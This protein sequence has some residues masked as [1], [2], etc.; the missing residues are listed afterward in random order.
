VVASEGRDVVR[1]GSSRWPERS[2]RAKQPESPPLYA[3]LLDADDDLAEELDIRT[4]FA[5]RQLATARVLE[6][7]TGECDL[8]SWFA[9]VGHGPGLLILD[10]LVAVDTRITNRTVTELLGSGDLLQ[11]LSRHVDDIVE[12]VA[13][14]RALRACRFALLDA[15]FAQRV[16]PWPQIGHALLRRTERRAEDLGV[17]RAISC[18]PRLEVR[19]VLFLWHLAARWGRVE[20]SGIRLMLPLTHRLLGQLVAAERPSISHALSRL[21]DAGLVSGTAGDWHLH[22][23]LDA[24]LETLIDGTARLATATQARRSNGQIA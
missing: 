8:E 17:L 2:V 18:Q 20:P 19:L 7:E 1:L 10:G 24:H 13:S 12:R 23:S 21:A 3:Y 22:G 6:T 9:V 5:A 4:R 16:L 11:P 15:E 14:W